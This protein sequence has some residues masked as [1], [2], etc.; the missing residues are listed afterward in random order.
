VPGAGA[1]IARRDER[2]VGAVRSSRGPVLASPPRK[3]TGRRAANALRRRTR[4]GPG[5]H[6]RARAAAGAGALPHD[7]GG[8][9]RARPRRA[10]VVQESALSLELASGSR[11]VCLPG[12][13]ATVRGFS[14]VALLIVDEATP[15]WGASSTP[16]CSRRSA[17]WCWGARRSH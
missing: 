14:A 16:A 11:V 7:E 5:A 12:N 4:V 10:P 2:A 9:R 13:E 1:R 3:R 17:P 8:T 6:P 15:R